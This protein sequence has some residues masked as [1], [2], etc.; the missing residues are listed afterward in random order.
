MSIPFS[1]TNYRI[2]RGFANLLE[3]FT[4][5]VLRDQPKDIPLFGAKYFEG[6]L[7][8]RAE[9]NFDP[10][11]WGASIED[12]FYNNHA[13]KRAELNA[14]ASEGRKDGAR[15]ASVPENSHITEPTYR[16]ADKDQKEVERSGES[17]Q[18]NA[19]TVIQ[20]A[21]RGHLTRREANKPKTSTDENFLKSTSCDSQNPDIYKE[22]HTADESDAAVRPSR[23]EEQLT[24][25]ID[26]GDSTGG[27]LERVLNAEILA[28]VQGETKQADAL[29]GETE[30]GEEV[31]R[32]AGEG[33]GE[34]EDLR[35]LQVGDPALEK[36]ALSA[37]TSAFQT[38][39]RL[40]SS[41]D[42]TLRFIAE[43][44]TE[45]SRVTTDGE[46]KEPTPDATEPTPDATEPTPDATEPTP[47]ATEPTADTTE[48]TPDTTKPTPD[49]TKPTPDATEPTPDTTKPTPDTTKPTP[50]AT[51]PTP[52][53]TEATPDTTK[54]IPDTTK[55]TPDATEP[56][57]D[58]T[59]DAAEPTPDA[60]EPTP[61]AAEPT[62]DAAEPTPGATPDT[63]EPTPDDS[64][65]KTNVSPVTAENKTDSDKVGNSAEKNETFRKPQDEAL[66]IPLDDPDAN[67]AAAKIQAGFRGHMT[68]KKMKSGEKDLKKDSKESSSSQGEGD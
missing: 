16:S 36:E 35:T 20:A 6:L 27:G 65:T 28:D 11:E 25:D 29:E 15:N 63:T 30:D 4:R 31:Q 46:A 47:D 55:P 18:I 59:P 68:R 23:G 38:Q 66:D 33:V 26:S 53:A 57:P 19:A 40:V 37:E 48:P 5:E 22:K 61:D 51:E 64:T 39:E 54:P 50:D 43:T 1:N 24:T 34:P 7:K 12:R 45:Q 67:A 44:V 42:P 14:G 32:D 17:G 58:A 41:E 3:G 13:F 2:P 56:T 52:D 49:T 21:F 9:T 10:A 8:Q 60:A 62:P